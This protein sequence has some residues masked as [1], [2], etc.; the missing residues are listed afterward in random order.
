MTIENFLNLVRDLRTQLEAWGITTEAL[1]V[2]G[3]LTG[4]IFLFSMREV[5]CWFF[6]VQTVRDEVRRLRVELREVRALLI[7][8]SAANAAVK[9]AAEETAIAETVKSEPASKRF[10]LDH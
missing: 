8:N 1:I 10:T 4:L 9:P 6:K 2:L 7:A 3:A 5:V